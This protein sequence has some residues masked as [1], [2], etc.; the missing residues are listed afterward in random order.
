MCESGV[1]SVFL[2]G[3]GPR[4]SA[5]VRALESLSVGTN[6]VY[7]HQQQ[8][9]DFLSVC[10]S[11]CLSDVLAIVLVRILTIAL[12]HILALVHALDL[13]RVVVLVLLVDI[14]V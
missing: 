14:R 11:V 10:L 2:G 9:K 7:Q 8:N 6:G 4:G 13:V 5:G 1:S 3:A 12:V